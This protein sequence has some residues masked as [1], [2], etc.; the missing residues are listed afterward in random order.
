MASVIFAAS[1]ASAKMVSR[2]FLKASPSRKHAKGVNLK[3]E[4]ASEDSVSYQF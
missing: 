1:P 2:V 3:A 4:V